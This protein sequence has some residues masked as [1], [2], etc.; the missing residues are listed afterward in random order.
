MNKWFTLYHMVEIFNLDTDQAANQEHL[1]GLQYHWLN[2]GHALTAAEHLW[3][4]AS[5]YGD[6]MCN[7]LG[8]PTECLGAGI[9]LAC[10]VNP[11]RIVCGTANMLGK[12]ISYALLLAATIAYH[13]YDDIFEIATLGELYL[14]SH[15]PHFLCK[16]E[17]PTQ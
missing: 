12:G 1:G 17:F 6:E 8:G 7:N 15:A 10:L 3:E 11:A 13:A 16:Y 5:N 14:M 4:Y 2:L 9:A